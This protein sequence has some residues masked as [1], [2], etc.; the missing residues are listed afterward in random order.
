MDLTRRDLL[1]MAVRAAA[2][3]GAAQFLSAWMQAGRAAQHAP[4]Q[5]PPQPPFLRDYKPRF[6]ATDDF[7]ALQSFTE[8][9]IPTDD[10]PGA[11]EAQCAHYIDFV[12]QAAEPGMQKQW[13]SAM[14]ALRSAGFHAAN[15]QQ[16]L[17]MITEMARPESDRA[18][19][20]PLYSVYRLIKQQN[21]FAFYTSRAGMI[22]GLDY[23]GNSFNAVF[24]GCDHPEHQVVP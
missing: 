13:S 10:T 14:S 5:A 2:L 8:I 15:P 18:A 17:A 20:H 16:R 21:T 7:D 3:P 4:S 24:P 11:R 23:R 12:L 22:E 1:D 19:S 6:F 9:L